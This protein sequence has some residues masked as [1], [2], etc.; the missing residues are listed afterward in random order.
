MEWWNNYLVIILAMQQKQYS[1]SCKPF[2]SCLSVHKKALN[3]AVSPLDILFMVI[4]ID[5]STI[6]GNFFGVALMEDESSL[7]GQRQS[8]SVD[9]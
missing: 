2:W 7:H 4:Y 8:F 3:I 6:T 9:R 5:M 1:I